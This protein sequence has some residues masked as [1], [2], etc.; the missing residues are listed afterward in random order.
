MYVDVDQARGD[1]EAGNIDH[2]GSWARLDMFS[3]LSNLV[4]F[5]RY[6]TD[7]VDSVL[8]IND[9]ATFEHKVIR[10][11]TVKRRGRQK[12]KQQQNPE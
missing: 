2:F 9:V 10:R 1:V 4:V 6:V 3:D 11:L 12:S 7:R 8:R 5:D